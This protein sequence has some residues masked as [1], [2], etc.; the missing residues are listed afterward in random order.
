MNLEAY[1][2]GKAIAARRSHDTHSWQTNQHHRRARGSDIMIGR[3]QRYGVFFLDNVVRR[4]QVGI[5]QS[6]PAPLPMVLRQGEFLKLPIRVEQHIKIGLA[7][8]AV[9]L[10]SQRPLMKCSRLT[11]KR[12]LRS[13]ISSRVKRSRPAFFSAKLQSSQEISL[14]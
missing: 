10:E 3:T 12:R 2:I 13:A 14:S 9:K 7:F 4:G 6:L 1:Q 11:A 8:Q 5:H